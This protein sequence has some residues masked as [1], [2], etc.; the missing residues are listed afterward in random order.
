MERVGVNIEEAMDRFVDNE[1]LL[2]LFIGKF[3]HD[4]SYESF[5]SA[6]E[7]RR[8]D[9]AFKSLHSLKGVCGNLSITKLFDAVCKEVEYLRDKNYQEAENWYPEVVKE[10]ER[11]SGELEKLE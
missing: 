10:Y 8:Y 11:V 7:E 2:M 9:D 1:E 6:M 3:A 4:P 5:K